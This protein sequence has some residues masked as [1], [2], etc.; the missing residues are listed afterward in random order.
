MRDVTAVMQILSESW[1]PEAEDGQ[2]QNRSKMG[3]KKKN[4]AGSARE[5]HDSFF[6]IS[7]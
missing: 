6:I 4:T 7:P 3:I 2:H 1:W 5:T